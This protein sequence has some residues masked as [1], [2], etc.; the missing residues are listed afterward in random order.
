MVETC[1]V[2]LAGGWGTRLLPLTTSMNKHLLPVFDE[3]MIFKSL[4]TLQRMG[5]SEIMVDPM[6]L[7]DQIYIMD[8]DSD[9][10]KFK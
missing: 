10:F 8:I 1:G 3:P 9:V 6:I 7:S 5:I 2:V 4:S